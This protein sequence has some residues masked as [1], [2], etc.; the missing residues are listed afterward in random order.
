V[1]RLR[2]PNG[3][4]RLVIVNHGW[5]YNESPS[6]SVFM[7]GTAWADPIEV[8]QDPGSRVQ[9]IG[10]QDDVITIYAGQCDPNDPAHFTIDLTVNGVR[11]TIDGGINNDGRVW[12]DPRGGKRWIR[13]APGD[14]TP[15]GSKRLHPA[16]TQ[17]LPSPIH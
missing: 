15:F 5:V 4:E 6:A 11:G 17:G 8:D 3:V 14:W 16:A 9:F 7:P 12:L 13:G 10:A 2:S 1:H